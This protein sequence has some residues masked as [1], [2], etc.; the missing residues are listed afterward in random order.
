MFERYLIRCRLKGEKVILPLYSDDQT[1]LD[2]SKKSAKIVP[3]LIGEN[4][5]T[6]IVC[7]KGAYQ[8]TSFYNDSAEYA[9]AFNGR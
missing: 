1:K 5:P 3:F 9:K 4:K 7:P 2:P 8:F 6:V